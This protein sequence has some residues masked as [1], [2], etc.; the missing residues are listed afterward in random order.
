MS[1]RSCRRLLRIALVM[2]LFATAQMGRAAAEPERSRE[3]SENTARARELLRKGFESFDAGLYE[4]ARE[5]LTEAFRLRQSY[6]VAAALGQ[7]ELE[8]GRY[9][10]AAE[11]LD[12]ALRDFP[13]SESQE[14]YDKLK[15]GFIEAKKHVGVLEI[16]FDAA[17]A[18][19]SVDG[20]AARAVKSGALVYVM[21]GRHELDV[22]LDSSTQTRGIEV[23]AGSQH[24]VEF[25][26]P[27][28]PTGPAAPPPAPPLPPEREVKARRSLVPVYV[29]A[30]VA[31]AGL[32][33]WVGFGLAA[34]AD[35]DEANR[36]REQL[37]SSGCSDGTASPAEC[38]AAKEAYDSQRS[39]ATLA[40]VSAG[41]CIAASTITLGYLLFWP[42][43]TPQQAHARLPLSL[44]FTSSSAQGFVDGTF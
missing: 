40:N 1:P 5:V 18:E 10:D 12:L 15:A 21:P 9:T 39:H 24:R 32:A 38:E 25:I 28:Q 41:I 6:D 34:R 29:G 14:L 16:S 3:T 44:S 13:P 36:L 20:A 7:A 22:T 43:R 8:L 23:V 33:G 19:I 26:S 30:S 2:G 42:S 17:S 4:N 11:H 31:V 35:R 27:A 37:G